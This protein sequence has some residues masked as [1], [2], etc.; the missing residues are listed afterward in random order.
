MNAKPLEIDE[1]STCKGEVLAAVAEV[2][3]S[4]LRQDPYKSLLE[5]CKTAPNTF[6]VI[7]S[8]RRIS[9]HKTSDIGPVEVDGVLVS[10]EVER[11]RKISLEAD[12]LQDE[13]NLRREKWAP[14]AEMESEW[15]RQFRNVLEL[16]QVTV[17]DI[18]NRIDLSAEQLEEID[19]A[20]A[21]GMNRIAESE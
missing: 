5:D 20:F 14:I 15:L 7:D 1:L 16:A 4:A 8:M 12:K 21:T 17:D 6:L 18:K 9:E 19:V 13:K 11:C 3:H 2:G 10:Y